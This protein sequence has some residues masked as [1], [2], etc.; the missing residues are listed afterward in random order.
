MTK[1]SG[2]E[3][4]DNLNSNLI[5]ASGHLGLKPYQHEVRAPF[6]NNCKDKIYHNDNLICPSK[7][8]V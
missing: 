5:K 6:F 1:N 4:L 7:V 8:K 2:K 3:Y